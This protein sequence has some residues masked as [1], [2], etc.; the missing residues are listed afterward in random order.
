MSLGGSLLLLSLAATP[1]AGQVDAPPA[2]AGPRA[3][4]GARAPD[5]VC[6]ATIMTPLPEGPLG[7]VMIAVT[8]PPL[9]AG[10]FVELTA[11]D[12]GRTIVAQVLGGP[13][14]GAVVGLSPGAARQL[15]VGDHGPVRVRPVTLSVADRE[16]LLT[17][18]SVAPRLDAPPALLAALRRKLPEGP[19]AS[20]PGNSSATAA[21]RGAPSPAVR[22]RVASTG[23]APKAASIRGSWTVQVVALSSGARAATLART[24]GGKV[25][26]SGG[27]YRVQ[28]GP[29][30]DPQS[31]KRARDG[32]AR[33][34]YGDARILHSN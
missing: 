22:P 21:A 23:T 3:T 28:L 8:F 33:A 11:L 32:I 29:Y 16:A 2:G 18:K 12:S 27:L 31:A 7:P 14:D 10:S 15:G 1:L 17:G 5:A 25:L 26:A 4:S 9:P 6:Y 20:A 19:A 34:G 24:L 30:A 13:A